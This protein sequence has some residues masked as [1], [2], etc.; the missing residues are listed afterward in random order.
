MDPLQAILKNGIGCIKGV[1]GPRRRAQ[2]MRDKIIPGPLY[3]KPYT[4]ERFF[5]QS[6]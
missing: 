5:M 2:G 4:L 6:D 3:L 1:Y